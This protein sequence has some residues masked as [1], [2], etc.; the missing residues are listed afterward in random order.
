MKRNR[1][2]KIDED[3]IYKFIGQAVVYISFNLLLSAL[4]YWAFLQRINV[5][6]GKMK[7]FA[8]DDHIRT[9]NSKAYK[10]ASMNYKF[11]MLENN[12]TSFGSVMQHIRWT[13]EKIKQWNKERPEEN[14]TEQ[15]NKWLEEKFNQYKRILKIS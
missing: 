4:A 14:L 2:H 3:K 8:M 15:F 10:K 9:I 7:I 6:G 12:F 11:N 5:L 1:K 13:D